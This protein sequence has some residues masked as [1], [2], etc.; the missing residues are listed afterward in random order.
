[1]ETKNLNQILVISTLVLLIL[2]LIFWLHWLF[3]LAMV[4][5]LYLYYFS[6]TAK[7]YITQNT[8][9]IFTHKLWLTSTNYNLL[10]E[11]ISYII[12][13]YLLIWSIVYLLISARDYVFSNILFLPSL[14]VIWVLII[15]ILVSIG[16]L[17]QWI[18]Y[19]WEKKLNKSDLV[20][21]VSI[22]IVLCLLVS[23]YSDPFYIS[24]FYG[25]LIWEI[26]WLVAIIIF[27]LNKLSKIFKTDLFRIRTVIN[28]ILLLIRVWNSF[29]ILKQSMTHET[30]IYQ[31]WYIYNT[32]CPMIFS[33]Q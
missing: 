33:G 26:V 25:S 17:S 7:K 22:I 32:D 13:H 28:I 2:S 1:M 15:S 24:Y 31:T 29:P 10:T 21:L 3:S 14:L 18:I 6:P 12:Q 16:S 20:F 8:E 30:I 5:W 9:N 27:W 11:K 19:L 4:V 23:R